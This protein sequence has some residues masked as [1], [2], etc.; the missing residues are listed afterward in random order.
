M[1]G[2]GKILIIEDNN[3]LLKL[4][5]QRIREEGYD[6]A[7]AEDGQAGLEKAISDLPD[8]VIADL[9]IPK[10]PGNAVV[11]ILK[12][13]PKH[14]RIP[15]IMLSAFVSPDMQRSVEIPADCYMSKPFKEDLLLQKIEELIEKSRSGVA[16]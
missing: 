6:V 12:Q 1:Q 14:A 8:L 11:R 9:A 13:S 2:R 3:E 7:T 15:V 10:M 5:A 16:A 4:L